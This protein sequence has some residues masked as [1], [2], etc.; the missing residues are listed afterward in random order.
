MKLLICSIRP[1]HLIRQD[2]IHIYRI[3]QFRMMFLVIIQQKLHLWMAEG[4]TGFINGK[5]I[6]QM[7]QIILLIGEQGWRIIFTHAKFDGAQCLILDDPSVDGMPGR[8]HQRRRTAASE[9]SYKSAYKCT[10]N[11]RRGIVSQ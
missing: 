8:M 7:L 9:C 2:Q 6:Q 3:S 10:E 4:P 11:T 1:V 5:G